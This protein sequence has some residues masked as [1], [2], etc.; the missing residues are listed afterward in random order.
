MKADLDVIVPTVS[1]DWSD[2]HK[3]NIAVRIECRN[4]K[5]ELR[6]LYEK[7]MKELI[8]SLPK[9]TWQSFPIEFSGQISGDDLKRERC[10]KLE[11]NIVFTDLHGVRLSKIWWEHRLL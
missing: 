11:A 5:M 10:E 4:D 1:I 2:F 9:D 6:I 7:N 8:G 3:P